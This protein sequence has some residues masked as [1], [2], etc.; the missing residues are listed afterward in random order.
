MNHLSSHGVNEIYGLYKMY[1]K[2]N[3]EEHKKILA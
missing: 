2:D 1:F 3:S